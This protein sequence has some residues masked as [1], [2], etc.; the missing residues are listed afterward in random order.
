MTKVKGE[1][2]LIEHYTALRDLKSDFRN[3]NLFK[4]VASIVKGQ[5]VVDIGCGAA[6][7]AGLLKARGKMV[8]GIEPSSGMRALAAE[9]NPGVTILP[10]RAEKVDLLVRE[11]VDTVLMIDVLEHIEKDLEQVK[12]VRSVLKTGGEFI[13]V[14][15]AHP[16]LFGTRDKQMGHYRRYSKKLLQEIFVANGFCIEHLRHWNA[17]GVLPYIISEKILQRPL[18]SKLRHTVK[19]GTLARV[20]QKGLN[21]WFHRIENNFDFGF[22]LSIIGVARKL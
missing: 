18:D 19:P 22:G 11:P 1:E 6:Y 16:F 3:D 4:L 8:T 12:K 7:L 17:L 2:Y 20:M 15:P 5:S 13:F 10:G 21:L 14:V 9:I